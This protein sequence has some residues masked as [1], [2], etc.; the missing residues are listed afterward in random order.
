MEG[1]RGPVFFMRPQPV[2]APRVR[3]PGGLAACAG[4]PFSDARR[5]FRWCGSERANE[6]I[7]SGSVGVL[8]VAVK[9]R[10]DGAATRD[11]LGSTGARRCRQKRLNPS[12]ANLDADRLVGHRP[13]ASADVSRQSE[14]ATIQGGKLDR[15]ATWQFRHLFLSPSRPILPGYWGPIKKNLALQGP[16]HV[17]TSF[18]TA[19]ALH[20]F[21]L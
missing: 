5:R 10:P 16:N 20:A 8:D 21:V 6:G 12:H 15:L 2:G 3:A 7:A 13:A 14:T 19:P 9:K 1:E 4:R 11:G 17:T 18:V